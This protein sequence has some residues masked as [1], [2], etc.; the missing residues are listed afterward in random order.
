MIVFERVFEYPYYR[1]VLF[2]PL[3]GLRKINAAR[4]LP[5]K[6]ELVHIPRYLLLYTYLF[7]TGIAE[8]RTVVPHKTFFPTT[9]PNSNS[10][11]V[12]NIIIILC[13]LLFFANRVRGLGGGGSE[14]VAKAQLLCK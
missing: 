7:T 10:K 14:A 5:Q 9:N 2:Y 12:F 11:V 8:K 6:C 3:H 13:T 1:R 4:R